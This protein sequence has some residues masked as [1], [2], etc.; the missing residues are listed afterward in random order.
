MLLPTQLFTGSSG[1]CHLVFGD[2]TPRPWRV[3][4]LL[5]PLGHSLAAPLLPSG[6]LLKGG[7]ADLRG[8]AGQPPGHLP[9]QLFCFP[10]LLLSSGMEF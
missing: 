4:A 6:I 7:S 3:N 1:Q 10:L 5:V 8:A 2:F 9:R